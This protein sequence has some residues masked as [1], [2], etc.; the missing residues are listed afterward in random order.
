M[1]QHPSHIDACKLKKHPERAS[2]AVGQHIRDDGDLHALHYSYCGVVLRSA[3]QQLAGADTA[4]IRQHMS[5]QRLLN[6]LA[7]EHWS[8]CLWITWTRSPAA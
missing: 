8:A 3:T 4:A 7:T 2:M 5:G 1:E 6:K